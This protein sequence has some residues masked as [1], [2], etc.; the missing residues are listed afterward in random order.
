M[1]A[2]V[3]QL[4]S[5]SLQ[6]ALQVTLLTLGGSGDTAARGGAVAKGEASPG[7]SPPHHLR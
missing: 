7:Q 6:A 3:A 5:F 2:P 1:I 4:A